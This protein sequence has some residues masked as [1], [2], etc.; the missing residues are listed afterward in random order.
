MQKSDE[1]GFRISDFKLKNPHNRIQNSKS[2]N[3]NI[4]FQYP[5]F[6]FNIMKFCILIEKSIYYKICIIIKN[7]LRVIHKK[8]LTTFF[9]IRI[10]NLE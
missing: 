9:K 5:D 4:G 6:G 2:E 8:I 1:S 7:V 3:R 10:S